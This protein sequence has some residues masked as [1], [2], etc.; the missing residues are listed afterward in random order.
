MTSRTRFSFHPEGY[1]C[2]FIAL[3]SAA[4]VVHKTLMSRETEMG[5]PVSFSVWFGLGLAKAS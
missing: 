5:A 1:F 3:S 4:G 2:F